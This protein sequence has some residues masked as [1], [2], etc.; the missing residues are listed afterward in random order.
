MLTARRR[1][2][3]INAGAEGW[4]SPSANP[5]TLGTI[6]I[7][8]VKEHVHENKESRKPHWSLLARL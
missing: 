4:R 7:D 3:D 8:I 5:T 2:S 6:N 1:R